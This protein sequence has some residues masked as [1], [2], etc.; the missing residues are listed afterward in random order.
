MKIKFYDTIFKIEFKHNRVYKIY[1]RDNEPNL[2]FRG[3][4]GW[5]NIKTNVDGKWQIDKKKLKK[6]TM[7]TVAVLFVGSSSDFYDLN[8]MNPI[9]DFYQ[10]CCGFATCDKADNF[11]RKIGRKIALERLLE[12]IG[13]GKEFNKAV[14]EQYKKEFTL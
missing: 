14:W 8:I 13:K 5:K 10:V 1:K 2:L 6:S 12:T 7:Q 11:E 9:Y 3:Y 4:Q